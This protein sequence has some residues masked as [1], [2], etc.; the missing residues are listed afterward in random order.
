MKRITLIS[1]LALAAL[2]ISACGLTSTPTPTATSTNTP[3]PDPTI[4]FTP[5]PALPG[6]TWANIGPGGGGW[7][8]S[9]AFAPPNTIY[10]GC[11]VG[12]V[13]RSRDGGETF[14]IINEGLRNYVILTIVVHPEDPN[15]VFL[16]TEG[17]FYKSTDGGDHWEWKR[18]GFPPIEDW[19][20]SAPITSIAIDPNNSDIIY[21][22]IGESNHHYFGQG[23]IYKSA[24]GGESWFVVNTRVNINTE[25]I[26][27]SILIHPGDSDI[28]YASTDFGVYQS[29]DGGVSWE[30]K[31]NGLPHINTRKLVMHPNNPDTLYLTINSTPGESPWRGGVYKSTD[32][33]ETWVRKTN[34]L[35]KSIGVGLRTA[36]YENI[37]IDPENP[38]VLYVGAISWWD[39]GIYKST[40]GGEN[41][42]LVI[43]PNGRNV[44][45]GWVSIDDWGNPQGESMLIDPTNPQRIFF[46]DSMKL[47]RS[48]D[49]G[50]TWQQ[51][52]TNETPPGSG[53]WQGRGLETTVLHDIEVDPTNSDIVYFGY[54]DIGFFKTVDGGQSFKRLTQGLDHPGNVF[55]IEIDPDNPE[56]IYASTG[57]WEWVAGDIAKSEDGG[58]SWKVIGNPASGLPDSQ[59][60]ALEI[61]TSSPVDNRILYAAS[62]RHG[63][64]KSFDGGESWLQIN[65]GLGEN[66]NLL[67]S[68]LV[69][70]PTNPNIIYV[71]V[72]M[73]ETW[74]GTIT[75]K[76]H[77]GLYRTTDGGQT[78]NQL[79]DDI[80]N[81]LSVAISPH[82]PNIIFISARGYWDDF[83]QKEYLGG[84]YRSTDGGATWSHVFE[85]P[86][87]RVVS[88]DP[89]TPG[90]V[91]AGTGDNPFHDESTGHGLF[92]SIDGGQTWHPMNDGLTHLSINALGFDPNDPTVLYLGTGGNGVF[93]GIIEEVA[94]NHLPSGFSG[95]ILIV[96]ASGLIFAE[97]LHGKN[98]LKDKP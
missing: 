56:T 68:S 80:P 18:N 74:L 58:Q 22:G 43:N 73:E 29:I 63:V 76:Q 51:I 64:Y 32:G 44:E 89:R 84:V 14:E 55:D 36:N 15:I 95:N 81:V 41:W 7:L 19:S 52:Y 31:N 67:V 97:L 85:D 93:K 98:K 69:I 83:L 34:G 27:Y 21:A 50:A 72:D 53:F 30:P 90:L 49:A 1:L 91:Y 46:G 37:L 61:D 47:F 82:D 16:G 28:L 38:D 40:N 45:K 25:A 33:G 23:T 39:A 66:G 88:V 87:V 17:G 5:T 3:R 42:K 54:W 71:G 94:Q 11:D 70:D 6:I 60:Y 57:R 4:T 8:T 59:V 10:V 20:F 48:E 65:D 75:E 2:L 86:F 77:G 79:D 9:L 78:W 24:D 13:Y 62:Y 35:G 12:G 96:L 26:I 92:R